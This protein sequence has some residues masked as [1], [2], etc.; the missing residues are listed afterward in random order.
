MYVIMN[1]NVSANGKI[2]APRPWTVLVLLVAAVCGGATAVAAKDSP[3]E[4][5]WPLAIQ[6]A[7]SSNFCE[8]REGHFHAG[9]DLRTFGEEG[10]PCR[11]S[12]G[13]FVSRVRAS[14]YGYGKA[15]YV[16]CESGETLVYAH[17]SEFSPALEEALY[18]EQIKA[19]SYEVD[20]RPA[21]EAFPVRPG[22]ILAYT[23]STG[24]T[25]PHLHF[26]IRDRGENPLNPFSHGFALEDRIPPEIPRVVVMPLDAGARINGRCFPAQLSAKRKGPGV[27]SAADTLEIV[28]AVGISAEIFD[29]LNGASGRLAPFHAGLNVDGTDVADISLDRFSFAHTSQVD[30]LYDMA[31]VRLEKEYF[32]HLFERE[33]ETMWNRWFVDGGRLN[34]PPE[35]GRV[36][37]AVVSATDRAGNRSDL[38]VF[39]RGASAPPPAP[40]RAAAE[41]DFSA[42]EIP[43]FYFFED[44]ASV[45]VGAGNRPPSGAVVPGQRFEEGRGFVV[46]R[47]GEMLGPPVV[48]P[49]LNGGS[50]RY[51][52]LFGVEK[53]RP[54]SV[55]IPALDLQI[56]AGG[57]SVYND[58]IMYA[59]SWENGASGGDRGELLS[60]SRAVRIGPYSAT[61]KA[62]VK[63]SF[64]VPRPDSSCAIYRLNEQKME[65]VFY[66]SELGDGLVSTTA[67]RPGVYAVFSDKSAPGISRPYVVTRASY[68]TGRGAPEVVVGLEEDGSGLDSEHTAVYLNGVKQIARW[69]DQ[70]KKLFISIRDANIIGPQALTVAACDKIGNRSR[71]EA[72]IDVGQTRRRGNE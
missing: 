8:Y 69:D 6:P 65:W 62:D 63:I 44:F 12:C 35:D 13:G 36:H 72:T 66:E 41:G 58:M 19:G 29:R 56:A 70:Q 48:L 14:A 9:L 22:E 42:A 39:Y 51:L 57:N 15:V 53:G 64:V 27:Y 55:L 31:R 46:L 45:P 20:F 2:K 33:G 47:A 37:R 30:F 60:R 3:P 54:R 49:Y 5:V 34:P 61:L 21:L 59:S 4:R 32:I 11:A 17:L 1:N 38:E 7:I 25:S 43:G 52:H 10:V 68:A 23:G 40:K 16:Q 50:K 26:E 18:A 67:K 28:G 71:L 24:A